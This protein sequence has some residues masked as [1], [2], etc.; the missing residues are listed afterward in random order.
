MAGI[1]GETAK[2]PEEQTMDFVY[3]YAKD[4]GRAIDIAATIDA[5]AEKVFNIAYPY[6][7][8]FDE[9]VAAVRAQLPNLKVDI[10]PGTPPLNRALPLDITRAREMLDWEPQFSMEDAFAD[11]IADLTTQMG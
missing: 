9:L 1:T 10:V 5:P 7:T 3:L 4:C 2:I 8:S 6:V 11:Y